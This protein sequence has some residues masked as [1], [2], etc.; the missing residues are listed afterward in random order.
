LEDKE[1][2]GK[3]REGSYGGSSNGDKNASW[4]NRW[5]RECQEETSSIFL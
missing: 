3:E 4:R 5:S 2:D 1:I